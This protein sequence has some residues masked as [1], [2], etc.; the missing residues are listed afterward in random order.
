MVVRTGAEKEGSFSC[1][2]SL[3]VIDLESESLTWTVAAVDSAVN[4]LAVLGE[5]LGVVVSLLPSTGF[6]EV[7]ARSQAT[8]KG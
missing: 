5:G 7:V 2:E 3:D 1:S 8:A 6:F 4:V